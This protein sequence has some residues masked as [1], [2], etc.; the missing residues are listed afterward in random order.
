VRE[1]ESESAK[2]WLSHATGLRA[3]ARFRDIVKRL[4]QSQEEGTCSEGDD[5]TCRILQ[6]Y[7]QEKRN[8]QRGA[9]SNK[10]DVVGKEECLKKAQAEIDG[11][12]VLKK[13]EVGRELSAHLVCIFLPSVVCSSSLRTDE[14]RRYIHVTD[15]TFM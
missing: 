2:S 6:V 1:S 13:Q 10:G 14:S 7:E 11:L 8:E 12:E 3:A 4:E 9:E 5:G 15:L